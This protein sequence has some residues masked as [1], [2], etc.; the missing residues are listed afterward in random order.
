MS[1]FVPQPILNPWTD[2]QQIWNTW[3]RL[4]HLTQKLAQSVQ[5]GFAPYTPKP[6]NVYTIFQYFRAPTDDTVGR[7]FTLLRHTTRFCERKCL[8]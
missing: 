1:K 3:L 4:G 2:R 7:I 8:L 6:S 5:W